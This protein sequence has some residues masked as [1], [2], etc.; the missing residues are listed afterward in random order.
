MALYTSVAWTASAASAQIV[1]REP[2]SFVNQ[3]RLAQEQ[4]TEAFDAQMEEAQRATFDWGGWYSFHVF[5]FDDGVESSRTLR[6]HDLR[7]WGRLVIDEGVHEIYL[8]GRT[9]WLDFNTGDSYDGDDDSTDKPRME[10]A[11]YRF[12]LQKALRRYEGREI[13]TDVDLTIGRDLVTLGT[14]LAM[15]TPLDHAGIEVA[16]RDWE[17]RGFVGRTPGS[18]D[19]VDLTNRTDETDRVMGGVEIT[20][21]GWERHRPFVYAMWQRDHNDYPTIP[22]LQDF[23][24]DSFYAGAGS[25]G[26]VAHNLT[27]LAELVYESGSGT[28]FGWPD[29][30]NEIDAWAADFELEYLFAGERMP[31]AS[32]EYLFASGDSDRRSN[33]TGAIGGNRGDQTDTSFVGFGYRDT[34]ISFAPEYSNLHMG[35]AGFSLFPWPN[36]EVLRRLELGTDW[37]VYYK[38]H[39]DGAVSDPTADVR[40]GYLGWEM[41]YFAN[42]RVTND[43]AWTARFG[44][45]FPG[46][47][48]SDQTTRTFAMIGVVW[49][50]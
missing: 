48:F 29:A 8:R 40:S 6:R 28:N 44:A 4:M 30:S 49:S 25:T 2:S 38:H 18:L 5:I 10:R 11:I 36:E 12:D 20:F 37:F 47:A 7:L 39:R 34:G 15:S 9:S 24:Y 19:D 22:L 3:Q 32:L 23:D 46:D 17:L 41:D 50:F 31:R 14:G 1:D 27:Y 43:L 42:W 33:P 21:R 26:E 35:R 45:F 16:Y 13:E